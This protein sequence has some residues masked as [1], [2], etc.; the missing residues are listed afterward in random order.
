M[1]TALHSMRVNNTTTIK[2]ISKS[3]NK[4]IERRKKKAEADG[5]INAL[6]NPPGNDS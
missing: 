4:L 6:T 5:K 1:E 2:P 3:K